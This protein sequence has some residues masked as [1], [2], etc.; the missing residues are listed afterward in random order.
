MCVISALSGNAADVVHRRSGD[1]SDAGVDLRGAQGEP[2][3]AA[4]ADG[5]DLVAVDVRKRAEEV[6]PAL[7]S[8]ANTS[9]E[10]MRRG[11]PPLSPL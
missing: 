10:V 4:D 6:D 5:T 1:R 2:A 9:G 11:S 7:N 3:A 8:S